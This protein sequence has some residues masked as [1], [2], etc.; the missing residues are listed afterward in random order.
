MLFGKIEYVVGRGF[1]LKMVF[2]VG[3]K[4]FIA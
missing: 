2:K 3:K 4:D 1:Y